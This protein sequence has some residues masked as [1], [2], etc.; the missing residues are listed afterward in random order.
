MQLP[1][2]RVLLMVGLIIVAVSTIFFAN[3]QFTEVGFGFAILTSVALIAIA[4]STIGNYSNMLVV[5]IGFFI[6]YG[7]SGPMDAIWGTT[8]HYLF[9]EPSETDCFL[10]HYALAA[11]GLGL[12]IT[13]AWRFPGRSKD[14]KS[15]PRFPK[16]NPVLLFKL[17][18]VFAFLSS[19]MEAINFFRVGGVAILGQGKAVY[20][21]EVAALFLTLPSGEVSIL[22]FGL[23]AISLGWILKDR[24]LAKGIIKRYLILFCL[25]LAPLLLITVVLGARGLLVAW[26]LI[27]LVGI[28]YFC[29]IRRL[30]LKIITIGVIVYLCM[31]FLF[32]NRAIITT[33]VS[34]GDW[35][36]I[37]ERAFSVEHLVANLN[38]GKNEFGAAFWN[39]NEYVSK[40][41]H[42]M[43]LGETYIT[44]LLTPIPSFMYP[45]EKPQQITYV[46]RDEF[47]PSEAERGAIAGTGFSSM[48]EAYMNFGSLGVFVVYFLVGRLMMLLEWLR[49]RTYSISYPVFYLMILPLCQSF[50]RSSFG[51]VFGH[52]FHVVV[53]LIIVWLTRVTIASLRRI[54]DP[55]CVAGVSYD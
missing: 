53:L 47:F 51:V 34:S 29:P 19:L 35:H 13:M 3:L 18:V 14:F 27:L 41:P 33:A 26:F 55:L 17:A 32:A 1:Y 23:I 36:I 40:G 15:V 4:K 7:L 22:A 21:S 46:F 6:L 31:G 49:L 44:G 12:G 52:V 20:Q 28:T 9:S 11:I 16:V 42:S 8:R 48:L 24:D 25:V 2:S 39:F 5:F 45:G 50:H 38:P 37:Y 10:M 54:D 43:R 30:T